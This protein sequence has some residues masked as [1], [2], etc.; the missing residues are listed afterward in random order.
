M[1]QTEKAKVFRNGRSQAVRIP[2]KYRFT[3]D[4]VY[5]RQDKKTGELILSQKAGSWKELLDAIDA[6]PF[7]DDFLEDR[8]QGEHPVR[9]E[10]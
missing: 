4:E 1:A 7:P 9:E 10:L 3:T 6:S 5:I 2:A 8:N